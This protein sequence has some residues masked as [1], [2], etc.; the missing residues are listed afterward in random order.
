ML[1]NNQMQPIQYNQGH[2]NMQGNMQNNIQGNMNIKIPMNVHNG[3]N[4]NQ[5]QSGTPIVPINALNQNVNNSIE[6]VQIV[7]EEYIKDD[8]GADRI[9]M[10]RQ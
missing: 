5:G 7:A 4:I 6:R 8:E 9:R 3:Q 1:K 10:V 2:N